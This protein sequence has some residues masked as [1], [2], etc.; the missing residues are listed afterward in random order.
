MQKLDRINFSS[1]YDIPYAA[2][3][4]S[5]TARRNSTSANYWTKAEIT[6]ILLLILR[7]ASALFNHI[8]DC[9]ETFNYL[10]PI[11]KLV[12]NN[13]MQTWEYSPEYAIRSYLFLWFYAFPAQILEPI[14]TKLMIFYLIRCLLALFCTACELIFLK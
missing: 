6:F 11:S 1:S 7:L 14:V 3:K 10:E 9:D 4:M 8:S 2:S 5:S 13:G 12:F